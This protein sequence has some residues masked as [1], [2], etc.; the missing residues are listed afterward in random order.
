MTD[1]PSSSDFIQASRVLKVKSPLGE[2]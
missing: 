1:Q 2:D